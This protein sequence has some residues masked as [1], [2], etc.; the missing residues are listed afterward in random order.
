M[1]TWPHKIKSLFCIIG[2]IMYKN[3]LGLGFAI[4]MS[5][6]FTNIVNADPLQ[7][8]EQN[9][10]SGR[11]QLVSQQITSLKNRL[12]QTKLELG[13]LE[14]Q[15]NKSAMPLPAEGVNKELLE[16]TELAIT[17][18]KS[19]LDS[20]TIEL[21]DSQQTIGWLEKNIQEITNQLNAITI[22]GLKGK[23]NETARNQLNIELLYQKKLLQL[24]KER[25]NSLQNLQ[26]MEEHIL[27]LQKEKLAQVN[28]LL[29][30]QRMLQIK[31]EQVKNEMALQQKQNEWLQ[32][33]GTL[34]NELTHTSPTHQ[35]KINILENEIFYVNENTNFFYLQILI[36]RYKDQIRQMRLAIL[37]SS[38]I[39]LLNEMGNQFQSISKQLSRVNSLLLSRIN[40]IEKNKLLITTGEKQKNN[41]QSQAY[42]AKL[43]ILEN[44]YKAS[45]GTVNDLNKY[46]I[47]VRVLLDK[48]LQHELS[49]RQGL[50]S[51]GTKMWL[52]LGRE[53]LIIPSL[54]LQLFKNISLN[55]IETCRTASIYKWLLF[56]LL[57]IGCVIVFY[58]MSRLLSRL[59]L[60]TDQHF[61]HAH[62][63]QIFFYCLLCN[64]A[65]IVALINSVVF[66]WYFKIP[67]QLVDMLI[68]LTMVWI[69][70]KIAATFSRIWL[71]ETVHDRNGHDVKLYHRLKWLF[72]VG[73]GV[74]AI[75]V[76]IHQLP[77]IYSIRELSD[78]LFLLFLL[79]VSLVLF[80]S[81]DVILHTILP[82][83]DEARSY[84][85]SITR[86]LGF[87]LPTILLVNSLMGIFG[88]VN[89]VFTISWY[90]SVFLLVLIG[91]LLVCGLLT[92]GMERLSMLFIQHLNNGWLWTEAFLK[93]CDKVLRIILFFSSWALLFFLYGWD[94][95]SPITQKLS[96]LLHYRLISILNTEITL[97]NIAEV[98]CVISVF[99]WAARWAREFVYRFLLSRTQDLG[100]RNSIAILSQYTVIVIGVFIS[101]DVLGINFRALAVVAGMLAFGV[102][103]GLRDLANNFACGFLIL[104]ERPLRVGDIVSINEHEGEVM[105][106]GSRAI[107]VRSWDHMDVSIPNAEIFNKSFINWTAKDNIVRTVIPLKINRHD[108]PHAVQV[109][110]HAVLANHEKLL[111]DPPAEVLLKEMNDALME[112]EIRYFID[113]RR[114]KSRI[115]VRSTVLLAIWD[116]F[117]KHGIKPPYAQHEVYVHGEP[118]IATLPSPAAHT[119]ASSV[120]MQSEISN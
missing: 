115:G 30:S 41:Q 17:I 120:N 45:I 104:I 37:R 112:F 63:K 74:T 14:K 1:Q 67:M 72:L 85:R 5:L 111:K 59:S 8:T 99:Y 110:I 52:D 38:S 35:E 16:K 64:F 65:P 117:S 113:I 92:D 103:L 54:T 33:L 97:L 56:S 21:G 70:F 79:V 100:I 36:A 73:G 26:N 57:E 27:Q 101:M 46:L 75:S 105:H 94:M 20:A 19:N 25:L 87:A 47:R 9:L 95:Q 119:N 91:Y 10:D 28:M 12:N 24:E 118:Y 107:T 84:F 55:I 53:A 106:I 15:Q 50:P 89:L 23:S 7:P 69:C 77:F 76:F 93:P 31:Q 43:T 81:R 62:I 68:D 108:D 34:Q 80:K 3:N 4:F 86:L 29:K 96:S 44:Q 83:I 109:I 11:T 116:E 51:F 102:G 13:T 78:Q 2:K 82:H 58:L 98:S 88:Y 90:E 22:F 48:S 32:R 60:V 39:T 49:S 61:T 18:A 71:V 66:L 6:L 42:I 40:I 114:V